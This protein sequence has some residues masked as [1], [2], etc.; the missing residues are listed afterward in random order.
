MK[1]TWNRTNEKTTYIVI[2]QSILI[3][4]KLT[5]DAQVMANHFNNRL[6]NVAGK[7][8]RSINCW[9]IF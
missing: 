9:L 4:N 6:A 7:L 1:Q 5:N 3:I 8:I 2:R